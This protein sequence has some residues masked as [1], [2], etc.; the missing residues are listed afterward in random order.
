MICKTLANKY[1]LVVKNIYRH[2]YVKYDKLTPVF[3]SYSIESKAVKIM[4][5]ADE[6]TQTN[7]LTYNVF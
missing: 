2:R 6:M 7:R 5:K 1:I 3:M 4:Q